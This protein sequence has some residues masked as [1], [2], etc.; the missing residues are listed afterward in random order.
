MYQKKGKNTMYQKK[1][2]CTKKN[3][4]YQKNIYYV[5]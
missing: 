4:M 3:A 2:L 5:T 1:K